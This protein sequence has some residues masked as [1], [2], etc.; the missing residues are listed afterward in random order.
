MSDSTANGI[1]VMSLIVGIGVSIIVFGAT[2]DTWISGGA[3]L[4]A[5]PVTM[6]LFARLAR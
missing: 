3:L 1:I 2:R 6:A 4:V 5:F